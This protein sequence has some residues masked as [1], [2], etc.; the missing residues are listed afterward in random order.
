MNM[1]VFP[2]FR[3]LYLSL[4]A[5]LLSGLLASPSA[6]GQERRQTVQFSGIVATG[7][8]LLG[9]PGATHWPC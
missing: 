6:Y 1:P 4:V 9:V 2:P 3:G 7:D 5:V 8:S